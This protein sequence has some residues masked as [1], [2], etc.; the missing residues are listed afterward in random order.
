MHRGLLQTALDHDLATQAA[1]LVAAHQELEQR[2]GG[3]LTEAQA[4]QAE[5]AAAVE[6]ERVKQ[7]DAL[8]QNDRAPPATAAVVGEGE[9]RLFPPARKESQGGSKV[10]S[11]S[12]CR[13]DVTILSRPVRWRRSAALM[14]R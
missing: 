9:V 2:L 12:V 4:Q 10:A 8:Q 5:S 14:L 3:I 6:H 11:L 1:E 7:H 13:V